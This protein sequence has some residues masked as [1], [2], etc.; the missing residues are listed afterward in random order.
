MTEEE[1]MLQE[2]LTLQEASDAANTTN[3]TTAETPQDRPQ[4]LT[5]LLKDIMARRS[6]TPAQLAAALG[7]NPS[8]VTGFLQ[9]K[10][11]PTLSTI[12]RF[13]EALGTPAWMLL[14]TPAEVIADLRTLGFLPDAESPAAPAAATVPSGSAASEAPESPAAALPYDLLTVDPQTGETRL[15]RLVKP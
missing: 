9:G 7:L 15:Y 11:N 4:K 5:A 3:G 14:N 10:K 8:N 13:A 2:E 1:M 12:D 6:I